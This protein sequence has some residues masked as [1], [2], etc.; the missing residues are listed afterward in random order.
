MLAVLCSISLACVGVGAAGDRSSASDLKR[1]LDVIAT[2]FHGTLG[3]SLYH[4]KTHD[5]IDRLGDEK[6]RTGS[7]IKLAMLAAALEKEQDGEIGYDERRAITE[8]N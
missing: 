8:E 1:Q 6:F 2:S 7:T 4:R 5:R 3:Y